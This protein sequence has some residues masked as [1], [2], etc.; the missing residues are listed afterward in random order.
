MARTNFIATFR[1]DHTVTRRSYNPYKFAWLVRG[2]DARSGK[3]LVLVGFCTSHEQAVT[4]SDKHSAR[5]SRASCDLQIVPVTVQPKRPA[6]RPAVNLLEGWSAMYRTVRPKIT[7]AEYTS[8]DGRFIISGQ[9]N[10]FGLP[11]RVCRADTGEWMRD[12]RGQLRRF[13]TPEAAIKAIRKNWK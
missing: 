8:P 3:R 11:Y 4:E 9:M 10:Y 7:H 13:G 1:D 12:T 2:N 5:V 6:G